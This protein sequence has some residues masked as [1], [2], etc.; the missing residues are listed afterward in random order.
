M[1]GSSI[2]QRPATAPV[3]FFGC[4][5]SPR[6][7]LSQHLGLL[8]AAAGWF[9]TSSI[10]DYLLN[11]SVKKHL[12]SSLYIPF[13]IHLPLWSPPQR[14]AKIARVSLVRSNPVRACDVFVPT[15]SDRCSLP[16]KASTFFHCSRT[17]NSVCP[18]SSSMSYIHF[19][20]SSTFL[21]FFS[22]WT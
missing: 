14:S 9:L 21:S 15:T 10:W 12:Q 20:P 1:R 13:A 19:S 11:T 18:T 5:S 4:P 22:L 8:G 17:S 2:S 6:I 3:C 7:P 16:P